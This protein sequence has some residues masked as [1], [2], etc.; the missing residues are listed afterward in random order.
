MAASALGK[1]IG[2]SPELHWPLHAKSDFAESHTGDWTREVAW[3]RTILGK[4]RPVKR[5]DAHTA[6]EKATETQG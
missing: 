4:R 3:L 2:P 1:K 6:C 5:R